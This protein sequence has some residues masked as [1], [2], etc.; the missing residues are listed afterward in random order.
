MRSPGLSP[1][2]SDIISPDKL[3][4]NEPKFCYKHPARI[5]RRR[6]F[7]CGR[8][9]C[10][11]CQIS[12]DH[13]LFCGDL[14]HQS[15][16]QKNATPKTSRPFFLYAGYA[17]IVLFVGGFIYFGLLADAFYSGGNEKQQDKLSGMSPSLP[18]D[19][20]QTDQKKRCCHDYASIEWNE[21]SITIRRS[22][23]SRTGKCSCCCLS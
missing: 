8:A 21:K 22:R 10:P 15:Y 18:V 5:A 3:G 13:H 23:R 12:L 7:E 20:E 6:C 9:L 19:V 11:D 14:C 16:L 17:A 2:S 1:R 4:M